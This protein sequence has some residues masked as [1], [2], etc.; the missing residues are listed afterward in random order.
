MTTATRRQA[1][2]LGA[3]LVGAAV[4]GG[5]PARAQ[6]KFFR[7]GTGGTGGTITRLAG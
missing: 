1:L 5:G 6:Q 7:I 3:T 4:L 2:N